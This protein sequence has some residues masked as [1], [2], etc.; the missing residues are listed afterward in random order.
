MALFDVLSSHILYDIRNGRNMKDVARSMTG[1]L[2][3]M[4]TFSV[5]LY[6]VISLEYVLLVV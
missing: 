1:E 3:I 2:N 5:R 6:D 4:V